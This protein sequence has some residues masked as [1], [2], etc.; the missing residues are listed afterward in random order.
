MDARFEDD[1]AELHGCGGY[2]MLCA[3][4]GKVFMEG[5][6]ENGVPLAD[7]RELAAEDGAIVVRAEGRDIRCPFPEATADD[8]AAHVA[9][10]G[11]CLAAWR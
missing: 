10:L 3:G 8:L 9:R 1:M 11:A 7:V 2:L 6:A 5:A 4:R